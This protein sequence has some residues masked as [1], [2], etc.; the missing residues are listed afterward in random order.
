MMALQT[1][2]VGPTNHRGSRVIVTADGGKHSKRMVVSWDHALGA[3]GNHDAA[4]R[5]L[6]TKLGWNGPWM[7]GDTHT[8]R[9]YVRTVAH[10]EPA[11]V[12][13]DSAATDAASALFDAVA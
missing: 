11:F 8:G 10:S 12:V 3:D 13:A 1:R 7:A 9:V 5:A 2:F 6:A 4:A